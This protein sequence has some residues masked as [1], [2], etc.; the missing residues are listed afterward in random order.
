VA[1]VIP[2]TVYRPARGRRWWKAALAV[3]LFGAALVLIDSLVGRQ[4]ERILEERKEAQARLEKMAW[5][6][7]RADVDDITYT[8]DG[9]YKVTLWIENVFPEYDFY[10]MVPTVRGFI[11]VGPQWQEV[12]T[13][14]AIP[15]RGLRAGTVVNLK[16]KI[17]V[18]WVLDIETKDY[19]ELL[20]GYMH[21]QI[22]NAMFVSPQAEPREG[23]NIVERN[24]YY[25]VHL[26]P[27]GADD[28]YLK[29]INHFPAGTPVFIPM[30]P[31]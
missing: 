26:K 5:F 14:E 1:S 12:K 18:S 7:L 16:E 2:A 31:H 11:Q 20:P 17:R 30:P 28:E 23:E 22:H 4:Q 3:T 27:I 19:F 25:Y 13:V 29:R 15:D 6:Y 24:D 10:L 9:K 8:P 21:V